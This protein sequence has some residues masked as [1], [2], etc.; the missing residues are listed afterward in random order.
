MYV[1]EIEVCLCVRGYHVYQAL[2]IPVIGEELVCVRELRK[3]AE[4]YAVAV[5]VAVDGMEPDSEPFGSGRPSIGLKYCRIDML[6][7]PPSVTCVLTK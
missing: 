4:R 5:A 7:P 3:A 1:E 6:T 2:W